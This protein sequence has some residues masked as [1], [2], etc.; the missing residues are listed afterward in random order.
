MNQK[1]F[2]GLLMLMLLS[3]T[4][5]AQEPEKGEKSTND[6]LKI[7][8]G[9]REIL[10]IRDHKIADEIET[11]KN[12]KLEFKQ[13][14][15]MLQDSIRDANS[16]LKAL[17]DE[18]KKE[19]L[20]NKIEDYE[21]QVEAMEKGIERIDKEIASIQEGEPEKD[22]GFTFGPDIRKDFDWPFKKNKRE[23]DGHWAGFDI[24]VNNFVNTNA[25]FDL[26][27]NADSL[28]LDAANSWTLGFN[29]LEFNLGLGTEK[30]GLTTGLGFKWNSYALQKPVEMR[31]NDDNEMYLM[32]TN[33]DYDKN[34]FNTWHLTAPLLLEFQFPVGE[35]KDNLLYFGGG[36]VGS[37]RL[38]AINKTE[39]GN[40]GLDFEQNARDDFNVRS[41]RYAFRG[42]IGFD[43]LHIYAAYSPL[44]LFDQMDY[45]VYPVSVGIKL[46]N[47]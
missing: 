24:G 20:K 41:F 28:S 39:Y 21:K 35:D 13:N 46:L 37:L 7:K 32:E 10:I 44:T 42:H 33:L 8:A 22:E 23:Y 25:G 30:I 27:G 18:A 1:M 3:M 34:K 31:I 2:T 19:Q 43:F 26:Q 12:G 4:A 14:I 16:R 36:A 15:A 5:I 38:G 29:L 45:K 17:E 9:D 11:L 47:F 6:T 40:S